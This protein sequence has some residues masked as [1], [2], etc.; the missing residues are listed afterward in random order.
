MVARW[1]V[2]SCVVRESYDGKVCHVKGGTWR[3]L[4]V[5]VVEKRHCDMETW[6]TVIRSFGDVVAV[7][8]HCDLETLFYGDTDI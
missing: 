4:S 5:A 7:K 1:R 2:V 6:S 3:L 8:R